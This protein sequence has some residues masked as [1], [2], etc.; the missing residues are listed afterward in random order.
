[1]GQEETCIS[2]MHQ[3]LKRFLQKLQAIPFVYTHIT[4]LENNLQIVYI[5]VPNKISLL[6]LN[7]KNKIN[8]GATRI[9]RKSK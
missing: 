2:Q 7:R 5:A 4:S 6:L 1:M 8:P 9:F 3:H